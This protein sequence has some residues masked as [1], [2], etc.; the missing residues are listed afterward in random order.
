[1]AGYSRGIQAIGGDI[2]NE[3]AEDLHMSDPADEPKKKPESIDSG[4]KKTAASARRR[5]RRFGM[6]R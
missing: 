1:L 4:I 5:R 3:V 6:F 2:I